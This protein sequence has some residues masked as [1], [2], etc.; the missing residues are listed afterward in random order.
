MIWYQQKEIGV[1]HQIFLP[2]ANHKLHC[3]RPLAFTKKRK[4]RKRRKLKLL[5]TPHTKKKKMAK[6]W[7]LLPFSH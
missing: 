5:S 2:S 7:T 6:P 3:M 1:M 4:E